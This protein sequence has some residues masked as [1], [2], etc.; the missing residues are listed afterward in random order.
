MMPNLSP[1]TT[2][3]TCLRCFADYTDHIRLDGSRTLQTET[4]G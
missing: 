1:S 3:K 4:V 2:S